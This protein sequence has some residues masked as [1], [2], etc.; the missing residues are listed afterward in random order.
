MIMFTAS[1]SSLSSVSL[2]TVFWSKQ[3]SE[4]LLEV[5]RRIGHEVGSVSV[6]PRYKKVALEASAD[7]KGANYGWT[8]LI[9]GD[10][11]RFTN[12]LSSVP[13][14]LRSFRPPGPG[15]RR[16]FLFK[17]CSIAISLFVVLYGVWEGHAAGRTL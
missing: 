8:P 5:F 14:F 12:A 4:T 10:V 6:L 1:V 15:F 17:D 3:V 9:L 16:L 13:S 2:C 11:A 7:V